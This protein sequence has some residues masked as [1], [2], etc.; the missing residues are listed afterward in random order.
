MSNSNSLLKRLKHALISG[1]CAAALVFAP[2]QEAKAMNAQALIG[3]ITLGIA[4]EQAVEKLIEF[5]TDCFTGTHTHCFQFSMMVLE[6]AALDYAIHMLITAD[7]QSTC[8]GS[9]CYHDR[10]GTTSTTGTGFGTTTT[11]LFDPTNPNSTST[12]VPGGGSPPITPNGDHPITPQMVFDAVGLDPIKEAEA[13]RLIAEGA[14]RGYSADAKTGVITTPQGK[15]SASS[16]SSA[17]GMKAAGL[18][19]KD[20]ARIQRDREETKKKIDNGL[21][22]VLKKLNM[23][24]YSSGGGGRGSDMPSPAASGFDMSKYMSALNKKAAVMAAKPSVAGLSKSNGADRIGVANDNL[25]RMVHAQ[26]EVQRKSGGFINGEGSPAAP[27][28]RG[29]GSPSGGE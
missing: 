25:F 2:H 16:M 23:E 14:K 5:G 1:I 10:N 19:D 27:P 17:A 9:S 7:N 11:T 21:E 4:K 20:I 6:N 13:N 28:A 15:V 26:Y 29:S 3:L 18:S 12:T 24:E 8:K 22:E